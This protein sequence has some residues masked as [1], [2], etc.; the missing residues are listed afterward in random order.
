MPNSKGGKKYKRNK[1]VIQENKNIRYKDEKEFQEYAQVTKAL[2]NCRFEVLCFDGKKRLATMCGKMRKRVFVNQNNLVLVS[3]REWQDDK[4]DIIE[5]YNDSDVQKFKQ[6]KLIP[7]FIKFEEKT[8]IDDEIMDDNMG[9]T[10][11]MD[12]PSESD[13]EEEEELDKKISSEEEDTDDEKLDI[14][15]I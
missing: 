9:F 4:C 13:S 14:N 1:G 5:K 8:I 7:D 2:G 15:N 6:Q 10:F 11:N 3:L 12:M